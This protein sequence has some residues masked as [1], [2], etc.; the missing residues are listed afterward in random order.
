MFLAPLFLNGD[1]N[2]DGKL[3]QAEFTRLGEEWFGVWDKS[4]S[5]SVSEDDLQA[6]LKTILGGAGFGP[7]G[8]PGGGPSMTGAKG[9]RNGMSATSGIEFKYVHAALE[10]DSQR[11]EE[12]GVRY[13]GNNTFMEARDTL[14]RSLKV[15]LNR[16]T[17]GQKL[18]GMTK[19][20]LHNNITDASWMNEPLSY[21]LFRDAGVPAGRTGYARVYVTVPG[22]F[23]RQYFG[24]YSVVENPDKHFTKRQFGATDGVLFKPVGRNLFEY[25]GDDWSKYSQAYDPKT[26]LGEEDQKRVIAFCKLV[27]S[28]TDDEFESKLASFLEVDEFARFM[29][30]TV[31]LANLDSLLGMGQ[32]YYVYLHPVSRKFL[33]IPWDLDH[34]FGQ[35]PMAGSREQIINL[36][37][38]HPWRG[39]NRFLERVFKTRVFREAY[40]AR[41]NEFSK[42][43]FLAERFSRQVDDLAKVLRPAVAEESAEKLARFDQVVAGRESERGGP[44]PFKNETTNAASARGNRRPPGPGFGRDM[45]SVGPIK[46]FVPARAQSVLD[47]LAGKTNGLTLGG[48]GFGGP[49]GGFNPAERIGPVLFEYLNA[50]QTAKL[51]REDFLKSWTSLF[52]AWNSDKTGVLTREQL[53][54]GINRD[55]GPRDGEF[56]FPPEGDSD[57]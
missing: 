5:G 16:Y 2:R 4:K 8:M 35:F 12:V 56:P 47:Q 27:S 3:S 44:P 17:K 24:L 48:D 40:L 36:S 50:R 19:L 15:E 39:Q 43:L 53:E 21:R 13:K 14:K 49:P 52:F 33:F 22:K 30:V 34:S 57:N 6:G 26:E 37:V 20:N 11:F 45:A 51:S 18:A 25:Q 28:A 10:F 7:P 32:N 41:L 38:L 42:T 55:L 31:W 1:T 9:G 54:Q 29:G 46:A 23:E